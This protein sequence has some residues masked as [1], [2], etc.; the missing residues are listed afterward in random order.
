MR[1]C[2]P[3]KRFQIRTLGLCVST[4][5]L[6]KLACSQCMDFKMTICFLAFDNVSRVDSGHLVLVV[7]QE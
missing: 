5:V 7:C 4:V 2:K 6:R 3:E 1:Y